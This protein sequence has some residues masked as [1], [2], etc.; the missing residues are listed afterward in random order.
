M[1]G[2]VDRRAALGTLL[3]GTCALAAFGAGCG[4]GW[5][6]AV[7]LDPP[8]AGGPG[9]SCAPRVPSGPPGEG[10]V[11]VSL[12]NHP[13]LEVPG[14]AA[15]V[16]IPQA[17]LDVVVVHTSPGCYT[18]LW[19]ICTHGDCAVDWVPAD[20]VMECPCHGSRFTWEGQVLNGPATRPLAAFPVV[21]QGAS[22]FIY[23]P[24]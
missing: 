20:G 16:R 3:K 10:W 7:V 22:L 23:R 2:E 11:E 13:A 15:E 14:G 17:L 18:A 24:R 1:T 5:R 21:R 12:V 19:R 4:D 9:P 8:D 6:E